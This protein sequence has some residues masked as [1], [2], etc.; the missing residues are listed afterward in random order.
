MTLPYRLSWILAALM[1]VQSVAG[2]ILPAQYRDPDWIKAAWFANDSVTAVAALPLLVLGLVHAGSGSKRGTF[3]WLGV[4]C[5]AIYNYAYYLFGAVLNAFFLFYVT[6]L[7]IAVTILILALPDLNVDELM[8]SRGPTVSPRLIGGYF[9]FT[10]LGLSV[11][12]IAMW[13]GYVFAGWPTPVPAEIF[14]LVA[15]LDLSLMAPPLIAGGVLLWRQRPWGHVIS[16]LAGIQ[17]SLYLLVL[18]AGSL[19]AVQRGLTP[20]PGEVP[21]WAALALSTTAVTALLLKDVA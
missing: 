13:G 14:K 11:A 8:H 5:Y 9:V 2:L 16:A 4:I 1:A 20:A 3:V 19:V 15:A 18:S 7:V 21:L 10:G 12:W 17:A 6:P